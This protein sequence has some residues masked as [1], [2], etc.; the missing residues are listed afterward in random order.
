MKSCRPF[1]V[2]CQM[3]SQVTPNSQSTVDQSVQGMST[4]IQNAINFQEMKENVHTAMQ[5][6]YT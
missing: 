6:V 1:V 3:S 2:S 5:I 4:I